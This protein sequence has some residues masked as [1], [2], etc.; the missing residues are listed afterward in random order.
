MWAGLYLH[1]LHK[2]SK[3]QG[4]IDGVIFVSLNSIVFSIVVF[5]FKV[6]HFYESEYKLVVALLSYIVGMLITYLFVVAINAN[7]L[8]NIKKLKG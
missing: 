8:L 6:S 3:L 2:F 1:G 4:L 7:L 5:C